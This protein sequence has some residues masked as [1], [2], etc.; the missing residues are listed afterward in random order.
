M[1]IKSCFEIEFTT[2]DTRIEIGSYILKSHNYIV[3]LASGGQERIIDR[4]TLELL[5]ELAIDT[6]I[7]K[8]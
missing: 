4:K 7:R 1:I 2:K 5:V 3:I 6:Y 8:A